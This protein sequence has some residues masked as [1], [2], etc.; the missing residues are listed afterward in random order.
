MRQLHKHI[1]VHSRCTAALKAELVETLDGA[2]LNLAGLAEPI[3]NNKRMDGW[4]RG[5]VGGLM[6]GWVSE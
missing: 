3:Q 5:W 2:S 4:V 6:G 1:C